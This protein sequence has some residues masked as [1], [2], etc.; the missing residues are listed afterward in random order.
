MPLRYAGFWK[1]LGALFVDG[2]VIAP[3]A[4]TLQKLLLGGSTIRVFL[5]YFVLASLYPPYQII[6]HARW[7]QTIGKRLLRIKVVSA[8]GS[9][10][11]LQKAGL[12]SVYTLAYW[13]FWI[14]GLALTLPHLDVRPG[15]RT[16]L[17]RCLGPARSRGATR[18]SRT[19]AAFPAHLWRFTAGHT[20]P[21]CVIEAAV[22]QHAP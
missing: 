3:V 18:S 8:S 13:L 7:G 15:R 2:L 20:L 21:F 9:D 12:R 6:C 14:V 22:L 1:Q 19:L 4:L 10:M 5:S 17:L 16:L 11:T